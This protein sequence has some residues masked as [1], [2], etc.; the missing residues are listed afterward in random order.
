[1]L[2]HGPVLPDAQLGL[3]ILPKFGGIQ[4]FNL[5]RQ[6]TQLCDHTH[7]CLLNRINS[8]VIGNVPTRLV[9]VGSDI[10]P[11]MHLVDTRKYVA[12]KYVALSH[13]WGVLSERDK[14]CLYTYN[15]KK[16][17][18]TIPFDSLPKTFRDAVIVTW[19]LGISYLWIDS[20]CIIQDDEQDWEAEAARMGLVFSSAYCTIAA[21]SATSSLQGFLGTRAQRAATMI[22]TLQGR[23]CLAEPIDDF[24]RDV[25]QGALNKR[26]WVFQERALSRRTIHF[27]STQVYWECGRGIQCET[28]AKLRK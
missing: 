21:S 16:L 3:P 23:I 27:T 9:Y 19:N 24:H 14:F 13:C 28:Q 17:E 2:D 12:D 18:Q 10:N 7:S 25:E 26:G 8:K 1:V 15:K 20:L 11:K 5:L 4:Q 22:N 6:W